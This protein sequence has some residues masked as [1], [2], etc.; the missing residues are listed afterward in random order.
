MT[1]F[2]FAAHKPDTFGA[3]FPWVHILSE[4]LLPFWPNRRRLIPAKALQPPRL[5][6]MGLWWTGLEAKKI[7]GVPAANAKAPPIKKVALDCL[8][9]AAVKGYPSFLISN[10]IFI[11]RFLRIHGTRLLSVALTPYLY[12]NTAVR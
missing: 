8:D 5:L 3:L 7:S 11:P 2:A 1:F 6:R 4:A 9:L 10:I 12:V